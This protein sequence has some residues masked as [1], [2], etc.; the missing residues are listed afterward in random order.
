MKPLENIKI[1]DFTRLLPGPMA[2]KLLA[3]MGAEVIKIESPK[4]IDY[5]RSLGKQIDGA[6]IFF[7]QLN[8][9]KSIKTIDYESEEGRNKIL[10]LLK[11]A[12][13]IVEQFRPGVMAAWK[14]SY[15]DVKAINPSIVYASITGYGQSGNYAN[16]AG[17]D[18]NYLAYTGVMSLIKDDNGKPIL[19]DTQFADI[20]GSYLAA[21]AIQAGIIQ[22]L[23]TGKGCYLD[24]PLSDA[25]M[26]FLSIP[27]NLNESGMNYRQ[28]N[29]LNGK[30]TVNYA[31]YQCA[32]K[33]WLAVA[34]LEVKFWNNIC[35]ILGKS[36]WKRK[37][38]L[39]LVNGAFPKEQLIELFLSKDRD[40]WIEIF[41]GQ[42]TCVA[43]IL[44]L[45][46]LEES[47]FHKS[48]KTF[49]TF[50]TEGGTVLKDF[51]LPFKT[52]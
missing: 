22:K 36:D 6:S 43:P 37:H 46:E 30:T 8:H 3:Q 7:H 45:E 34:A 20:S 23:K 29:I 48:K 51:K 5:A 41:K 33:K 32:D 9:E 10:E 52:L 19:P 21:M 31:A 13:V 16:E 11:N 18:F 26:P 1:I 44:E 25:L 2:T 39:E 35:E 12:D 49:T 28:F 42:D 24:I 4:R 27:Y 17:H 50:A 40:D 38:Q 15:E 14:L 47:D